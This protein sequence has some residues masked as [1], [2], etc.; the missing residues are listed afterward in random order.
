[1]PKF[2][3][4]TAAPTSDEFKFQP[5]SGKRAWGGW[6]NW[7]T[8]GVLAL[9]VCW[10]AKGG[11]DKWFDADSITNQTDQQ[12]LI[13]AYGPCRARLKLT[14]VGTGADLEVFCSE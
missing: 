14:T 2:N 11:V 6:G 12:K 1:M 13:D 3:L 5:G 8:T 7:G 4:T 9:Q 10:G